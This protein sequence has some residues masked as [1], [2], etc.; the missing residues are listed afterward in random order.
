MAVP[1]ALTLLFLIGNALLIGTS[2]AGS[3]IGCYLI[4]LCT[5]YL[6]CVVADNYAYASRHATS[7]ARAC[8]YLLGVATFFALFIAFISFHLP[9]VTSVL[10]GRMDIIA[11]LLSFFVFLAVC[12]ATWLESE[13][14]LRQRRHHGET[15]AN[16][17]A[18]SEAFAAVLVVLV[19]VVLTSFVA[20]N[21]DGLVSCSE[22]VSGK[23]ADFY[24]RD[25]SRPVYR[26]MS[27]NILL[28]H[29]YT[30]RDNSACVGSVIKQLSPDV[31][32]LQESDP[33]PFYWGGKNV[34]GALSS[35]VRSQGILPL[36][37]V[38]PLQSTLGIALMSKLP[39]ESHEAK[40]FPAFGQTNLPH[41]GYTKTKFLI[42]PAHKKTPLYVINVHA[43][44]KNWT[45]GNFSDMST[46]QMRE[47][48]QLANVSEPRAAVIVMGDLNLNPF[49]EQ[50]DELWGSALKCAFHRNR[51]ASYPSTLLN[52]FANV[53][54][55]FYRNLQLVESRVIDKVGRVSD[56]LP[57][58]ADFRLPDHL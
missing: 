53:D 3:V 37:G 49:E 7:G 22:R 8:S 17:R 4:A 14:L 51:T 2:G 57:V 44:Y 9:P 42:G 43:V 56:H 25:D 26:V 50:L 21:V 23:L 11:S 32:G 45:I 34:L 10:I 48:A 13:A 41:Y 1:S 55:I 20:Y 39:V 15:P 27:W 19:T 16:R 12:A 24:P 31:I 58:M 38:A 40:L 33:L 5:P 29:T 18:K 28:G 36:S 46:R 30:G 52:R 35:Q 6:F 54:H 47:V